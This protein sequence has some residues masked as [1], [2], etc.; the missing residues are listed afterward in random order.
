MSGGDFDKKE[1]EAA[2]DDPKIIGDAVSHYLKL[3]RGK[4]FIAR[5]VSIKKSLQLAEAFNAA[6]I[7]CWHVDGN[8]D[9]S[10][11]DM[12]MDD[13]RR[14]DLAGLVNVDLFSEGI[15]VPDAEVFVDL[16]PTK[17]LTKALQGWGRVLRFV[18][19]KTAIIL[20]HGGNLRRHSLPCEERAWSLEGRKKRQKQEAA[21]DSIQ[22]R[23]CPACFFVHRPAPTCPSCGHIYEIAYR[24][25][26]EKDG[27][28]SE[29]DK[30]AIRK[31]K[32]A[33]VKSARTLEDLIALGASRG[34]RNP[35]GWARV[36]I[37]I[38]DKYRRRFEPP[39]RESVE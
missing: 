10:E 12:A 9:Q 26:E 39:P 25:V 37:E 33:E 22:T 15:D 23:Q 1:L 36:Q 19:G 20:D 8:T 28:L 16:C 18:S 38:R 4:K 5:H 27:E 24:E 11:R 29:V 17:S 2:T 31:Q 6:G 3:A 14:G 34:Y 32:K 35:A 30:D 13:F 21:E 7:P